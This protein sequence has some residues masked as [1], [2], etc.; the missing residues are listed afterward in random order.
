MNGSNKKYDDY[1]QISTNRYNLIHA[2]DLLTQQY[3]LLV[4]GKI[5]Q[6]GE[7][8]RKLKPT[9][10]FTVRMLLELWDIEDELL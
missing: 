7:E 5:K 1:E 6:D 4:A 3:K 8:M 2:L 9:V 10:K